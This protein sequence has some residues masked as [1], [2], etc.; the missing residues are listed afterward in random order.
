MLNIGAMI[1]RRFPELV[2]SW[3]EDILDAFT[4]VLPAGVTGVLV[5]TDD[6]EAVL[7]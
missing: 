6:D 1:V 7:G 5:D 4:V 2:D 3:L